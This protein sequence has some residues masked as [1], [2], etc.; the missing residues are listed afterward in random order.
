MARR[1]FAVALL[2]PVE[3]AVAIDA[4]RAALGDRQLGRIPAHCTIVSPVNVAESEVE[5]ALALMRSG[6]KHARPFGVELG[7]PAT[8]LPDSPVLY[9]AVAVGQPEIHALRASVFADPFR[10]PPTWPF[11]PHVTL[12][13]HAERARIEAAMAALA[14]AR[15]AYHQKSVHLLEEQRSHVWTPIAEFPFARTA[16]PRH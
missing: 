8:F 6:A 14:D 9:L 5:A 1:R 16:G 12:V 13:D 10:R 2:P 7:P 4:L 3:V 15:F 11:V